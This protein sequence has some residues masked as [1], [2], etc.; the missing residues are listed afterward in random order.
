M[1]KLS[2]EIATELLGH[3]SQVALIHGKQRL[4]FDDRPN[5]A[6]IRSLDLP[7][8]LRRISCFCLFQKFP[9]L[10]PREPGVPSGLTVVSWEVMAQLLVYTLIK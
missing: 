6:G 3:V 1:P 5:S 4:R 7:L 2:G 8:T 10:K 9:V